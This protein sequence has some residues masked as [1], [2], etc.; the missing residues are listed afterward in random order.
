[1]IFQAAKRFCLDAHNVAFENLKFS[2]R[3]SNEINL[4]QT[5]RAFR[6]MA[7]N[8]A[9]P[10]FQLVIAGDQAEDF[11]RRVAEIFNA[12]ICKGF[13]NFGISKIF[14]IMI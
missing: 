10:E 4:R 9:M 13:G 11:F 7:A 6:G 14:Q 1:L 2:A 5:G 12:N 3:L 8:L